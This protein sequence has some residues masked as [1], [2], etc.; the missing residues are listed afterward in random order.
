[1]SRF[2][3]SRLRLALSLGVVWLTFGSAPVGAR[4]GVTHVPPFLFGGVRFV[5][6]GLILLA[7]LA[8]GGRGR[9]RLSWRELAEAAV[10]GV[11]LTGAGQ[12]LLNWASVEVLPGVVAMFVA[13]LP[14]CT[15]L[16]G[17]LLLGSRISRLGVAGLGLG[18]TGTLLLALP[19]AGGSVPP[20]A[21]LA[22][23][24]G[25]LSW[26]AASLLAVRS[27]VGRRPLL[28]AGLQM[29][30]G[31]GVQL[32][33]ALILGEPAAFRTGPALQPEVVLWF[34]Y[35]LL[36]PAVLGFVCF[37]W[38]LTHAS[39][40]VANSQAY[41]TPV[42]AILLGW[43]LLGEPLT[44]RTLVAAGVGLT[45]VVLLVVAQARVRVAA[46]RRLSKAA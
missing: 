30:A 15:A 32:L 43:L 4:V 9:L 37:S 28:L 7:A 29:L 18:V 20:G 40:V 38:L 8:V 23:V 25:V 1:M 24:G 2:A 41:V 42:V 34:V 13:T 6:A 21:A 44:P 3:S 11:G 27:R 46:E 14:L 5:L 36:G 31:G 39:P 22:L 26:A 45:G 16:L 10:I 19:A 12:G 33:M 17:R 35:L